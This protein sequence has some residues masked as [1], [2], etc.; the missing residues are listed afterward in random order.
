MYRQRGSTV[1][2]VNADLKAHRGLGRLPVCGVA[3]VT[4]CALWS[5][6]AYNLLHFG[7]ALLA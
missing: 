3:K 5:A 6:L 2:T 7:A 4:C 1:E